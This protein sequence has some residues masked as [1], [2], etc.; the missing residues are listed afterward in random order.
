MIY[1][2]FN[3][4][5]NHKID[6]HSLSCG[7]AF[8]TSGLH[9]HFQAGIMEALA[10]QPPNLRAQI[11]N[12]LSHL[13]SN[14]DDVLNLTSWSDLLL[15]AIRA[16]APNLNPVYQCPLCRARIYTPPVECIPLTQLVEIIRKLPDDGMIRFE[17]NHEEP[18]LDT[19]QNP[20]IDWQYYFGF[21]DNTL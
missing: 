13:S 8:S 21:R 10:N 2:L 6:I 4:V 15:D 17:K 3:F 19:E 18:N 11:L 1:I 12:A 14:G 5:S 9:G 20:G 16:A 7:H